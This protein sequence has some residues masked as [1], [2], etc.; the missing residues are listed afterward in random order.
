MGHSVT[1]QLQLPKDLEEFKLPPALHE[2]LQE[3]LDKQDEKGKLTSRERRE[4]E[5]LTQLVDMLALMK[6]R[7][8]SASLHAGA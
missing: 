8:E 4:A 3:L 7:V 1:V 6:L 2:R 5:A